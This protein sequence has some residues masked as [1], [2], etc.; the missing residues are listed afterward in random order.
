MCGIFGTN[1]NDSKLS[2][3]LLETIKNR[4]PDNQRF[5]YTN[6]FTLGHSRLSIIDLN[7]RSNQPFHYKNFVIIFNGEIYNY[8][9]IRNELLGKYKF[10]TNSDT[11]VIIKAYAEWGELCF[12]KFRGMWALCIFDKRTGK[13][14]LSKDRFG[15][16]PLYYYFR[17]IKGV[18]HFVFSSSMHTILEFLK[19]K[20]IKYYPEKKIII[21]YM[22]QGINN[23]DK[24]TPFKQIYQLPPAHNL[25]YSA[26]SAKIKIKKYYSIV[27]NKL[28][29]NA[30]FFYY[31][32]QAVQRVTVSDLPCYLLL[33]GGIDST[34]ISLNLS[35]LNY[36]NVVCLTTPDSI[37]SEDIFQKYTVTELGL[38]A[39]FLPYKPKASHMDEIIKVQPFP[40][41]NSSELAKLFMFKK[42]N[43]KS[44]KVLIDGAGGDEILLGYTDIQYEFFKYKLRSK[45][46]FKALA[47]LIK[48]LSN[49]SHRKNC[50]R[51]IFFDL[52][53]KDFLYFFYKIRFKHIKFSK[54]DFAN[55]FFSNNNINDLKI[56]LEKK[57]YES[58][59][60]INRC[61]DA[62]SMS[63]GIEVRSPFQDN[64]LV[65][66]CLNRENDAADDINFFNKKII[67]DYI[68]AELPYIA[69]NFNKKG[70][71]QL[72]HIYQDLISYKDVIKNLNDIPF[73]RKNI[74]S[75]NFVSQINPLIRNNSSQTFKLNM[76]YK[77]YN[78]NFK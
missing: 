35:K 61:T 24:L 17:K 1:F 60:A 66:F 28:D 23:Y 68:K 11:E 9:E 43:E 34:A 20:K 53:P 5:I 73:F 21:R 25:Y 6:G 63:F 7:P 59:I 64:D 10:K 2:S 78:F 22:L 45:N 15:M 33:S 38:D 39:I 42:L 58:L 47:L 69:N 57:L 14:I 16:K 77:W 13:I 56:V 70:M 40:I 71:M 26:I 54:S 30:D 8:K 46:F 52:T 18:Q 76:L 62:S 50:I 36:K 3:I 67:R 27:K 49:K 12:N 37:A 29:F 75:K 32:N 48:L 19:Y 72:D 44:I 31:F 41:T 74:F 55:I 65:E 4:G 51:S